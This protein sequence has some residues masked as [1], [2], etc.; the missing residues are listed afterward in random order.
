MVTMPVDL[1]R[2]CLHPDFDAVVNVGRCLPDG[3]DT[4]DPTIH[5]IG[6]HAEIRVWCKAC[7]EPFCWL[8]PEGSVG[9]Q[10]DRPMI[11]PE[12]QELRAPLRPKSAEPEFGLTLPGFHVRFREVG[13]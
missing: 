11:D 5:P 2:P 10:A 3:S 13:Q 12:A 4:D 9:L 1:D 7:G 8:M 6:Y